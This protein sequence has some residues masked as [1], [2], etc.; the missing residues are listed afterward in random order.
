MCLD[1]KLKAQLVEREQAS[2]YRRRQVLESPQGV[3]VVVNGE[4][5]VNF[6]SNDYL[7]LRRHPQ[8]LDALQSVEPVGSGASPVLTGH[9]PHH[10]RLDAG[11]G[12]RLDA[13]QRRQAK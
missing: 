8:I 12:S 13:D 5:F 10:R 11:N 2:L 3:D 4:R 7:G 9:T 6:S 1:A